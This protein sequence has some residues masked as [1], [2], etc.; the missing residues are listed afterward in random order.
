MLCCPIGLS[1]TSIVILNYAISVHFL[2]DFSQ[3]KIPRVCI[4]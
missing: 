1:N 4:H 2:I 3:N